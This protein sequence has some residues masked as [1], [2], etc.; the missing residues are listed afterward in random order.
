[1]TMDAGP[2]EMLSDVP[3]ICIWSVNPIKVRALAHFKEASRLVS[4]DLTGNRWRLHAPIPSLL[5]SY[6]SHAESLSCIP[7][8]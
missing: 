2:C 1:M 7:Y 3:E 4:E 6:K 8:R 5:L